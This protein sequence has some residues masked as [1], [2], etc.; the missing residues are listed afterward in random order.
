M[1]INKFNESY[2]EDYDKKFPIKCKIKNRIPDPGICWVTEINFEE[3]RVE[4]TNGHVRSSVYGF[5]KVEF[6]PDFFVFN[7]YNL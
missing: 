5:D 1:K 6:I 3:E 4:W 2:A 7:K